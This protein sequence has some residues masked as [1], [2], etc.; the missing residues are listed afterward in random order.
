[1]LEIWRA[2][3]SLL[4]QPA[5]SSEEALSSCSPW[6]LQEALHLAS[7]TTLQACC[8]IDRITSVRHQWWVAF[9]VLGLSRSKRVQ[10]E[11]DRLFMMTTVKHQV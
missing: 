8:S 5:E 11:W 3:R 1:M 4:L 10:K 2:C 9:P 6:Q 7:A